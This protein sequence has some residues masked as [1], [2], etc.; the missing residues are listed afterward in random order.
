MGEAFVWLF[1]IC[2]VAL[3][4]T[5]IYDICLRCRHEWEQHG[6]QKGGATKYYLTCKKCGKVKVLK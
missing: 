6:Y 5:M 1:T 3:I 4:A 2:G